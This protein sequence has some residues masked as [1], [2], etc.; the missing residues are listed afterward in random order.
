M[1][2][3]SFRNGV[4]NGFASRGWRNKSCVWRHGEANGFHQQPLAR[5]NDIR[6]SIVKMNMV[7]TN[8]CEY[9][10]RISLTF[11]EGSRR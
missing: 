6:R 1:V 7:G 5:N 2:A 3:H 8:A 9:Y 10:R 4:D 11:I